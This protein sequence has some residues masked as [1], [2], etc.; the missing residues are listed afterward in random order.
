MREPQN[1]GPKIGAKTDVRVGM[2]WA[3]DHGA[4]PRGMPDC[5]DQTCR[6][7]QA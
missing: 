1:N 4:N 2:P 3:D 7:V 6:R 5:P